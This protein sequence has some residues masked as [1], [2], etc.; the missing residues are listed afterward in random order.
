M[1]DALMQFILMQFILMQFITDR[2]SRV[3][4]WGRMVRIESD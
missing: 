1:T 2:I 4:E 3:G